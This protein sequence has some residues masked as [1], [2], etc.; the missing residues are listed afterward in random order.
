MDP[1]DGT[2]RFPLR[3]R[4]FDLRTTPLLRT[5]VLV[6]GGGIAGATAALHAADAGAQVL[7]LKKTAF[8][9]SNT[10]WAQGGIAA[11][12]RHDDSIELH[13]RDTLSVGAGTANTEVARAVIGQARQAL[14][15]LQEL[16]ARFDS[17][18]AQLELSRE[19]GH[20]VHRVVHAGGD[21]TGA[22]IQRALG[23]ALLAHPRVTVRSPAFV[24]DL[25]VDEGRC[26]GAT[27][28]VND[29]ELGLLKFTSTTPTSLNSSSAAVSVPIKVNTGASSSSAMF[30][31]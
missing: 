2:P 6:I 1:L 12:Q 26:V 9:E 5:D 10:A 8:S 29:T 30:T 25:V 11:A 13:L 15:W 3:L 17:D 16:G 19:G 31:V 22:E 7:L 21:T 20:S 28:L 24:H 18:G 14:A 4:G 27:V 23:E